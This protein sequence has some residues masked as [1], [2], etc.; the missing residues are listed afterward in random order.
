MSWIFFRTEQNANDCRKTLLRENKKMREFNARIMKEARGSRSAII[1][2]ERKVDMYQREAEKYKIE[3]A[4]LKDEVVALKNDISLLKSEVRSLKTSNSSTGDLSKNSDA[5]H[6]LIELQEKSS[7]DCISRMAQLLRPLEIP[8]GFVPATFTPI[9][10]VVAP[11][12]PTNKLYTVIIDLDETQVHFSMEQY[13]T[14][15][16]ELRFRGGIEIAL[17]RFSYL[18][19]VVEFGLWTAGVPRYATSVR[20]LLTMLVKENEVFNWTIARD[21]S[22]SSSGYKKDIRALNRDPD[23]VLLIDNARKVI[24]QKESSLV[25]TNFYS[26]VKGAVDQTF[27][28]IATLVDD[29]VDS[30]QTVPNFLSRKADEGWVHYHS[31]YYYVPNSLS[32]DIHRR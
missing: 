12:P 22:W 2:M 17:Q 20:E 16:A 11:L 24:V 14:K 29:L 15:K 7:W 26:N 18:K 28:I 23:R 19:D 6:L 25:V 4:V 30:G 32:S 27:H 5:Q 3:S 1:E 9:S 31:G 8:S 13:P 10:T 21:S